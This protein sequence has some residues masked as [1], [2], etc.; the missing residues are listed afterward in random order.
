MILA[1]WK[2]CGFLFRCILWFSFPCIRR[3]QS[4]LSFLVT[5]HPRRQR[6]IPFHN[7]HRRPSPDL[8]EISYTLRS[9]GIPLR[10]R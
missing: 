8:H 3:I 6:Q 10:S 5:V 2:C 1:H 9:W 4:Y 7:D